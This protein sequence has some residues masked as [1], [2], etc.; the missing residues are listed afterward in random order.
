MEMRGHKRGVL[1]GFLAAGML[2]F[3][4]LSQDVSAHRVLLFASQAGEKIEG[5]AY[6]PGGK[7]LANGKVTVLRADGG[8]S[9]S[10]ITNAMGEFVFEPEEPGEY[11]FVLET[12]D[13]HRAD[14]RVIS[15]T[16]QQSVEDDDAHLRSRGAEDD[17]RE[18]TR[19]S[20]KEIVAAID[21][22]FVRHV[23]TLRQELA[24]SEERV[25]LRDIIGGLGYIVG[26]AG[27]VLYVW[28]RK[29]APGDAGKKMDV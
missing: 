16:L 20:G 9:A 12:E 27:I 8:H 1:F 19:Q 14:Y 24:A 26:L 5:Y 22:A 3:F 15:G 29:R 23:G 13:G 6:F 21:E 4:S 2:G 28:G 10:L 7:R 25:R 18:E 17:Y 11:S